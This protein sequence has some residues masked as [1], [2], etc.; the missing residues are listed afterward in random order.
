MQ[1]KKAKMQLASGAR[2]DSKPRFQ[3]QSART[4]LNRA[5]LYSIN[6]RLRSIIADAI[7]GLKPFW[8]YYFLKKNKYDLST[9]YMVSGGR[10]D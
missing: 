7:D 6:L 10:P 4:E 3:M 2:R 9:C 1:K 5:E 8:A